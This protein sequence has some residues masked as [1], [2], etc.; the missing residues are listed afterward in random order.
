M[1]I[2]VRRARDVRLVEETHHLDA[3]C[4]IISHIRVDVACTSLTQYA[5]A[6]VVVVVFS[7]HSGHVV[8]RRRNKQNV[9]VFEG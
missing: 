3:C 1:N 9:V 6:C 5:L 4:A 7:P 8:M 2:N